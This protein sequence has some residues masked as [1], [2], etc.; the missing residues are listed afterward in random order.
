MKYIFLCAQSSQI[1]NEQLP[2]LERRGLKLRKSF[3]FYFS[4]KREVATRLEC[5]S[6]RNV[7]PHSAVLNQIKQLSRLARSLAAVSA[8]GSLVNY[9][10]SI[11]KIKA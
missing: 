11:D 7:P 9:Q 10:L 4:L 2:L 5:D 8:A 6:R 3:S 1:D